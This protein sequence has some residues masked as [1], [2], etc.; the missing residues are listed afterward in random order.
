MMFIGGGT[1][2][3]DAIQSNDSSAASVS[4]NHQQKEYDKKTDNEDRV[5]TS[6]LKVSEATSE[7]TESKDVISSTESFNNESR[8]EENSLLKLIQVN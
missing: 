7:N 2:Q 5:N 3:A 4:S 6:N 1:V 8:Q